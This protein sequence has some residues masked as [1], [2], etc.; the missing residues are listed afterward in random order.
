MRGDV[1]IMTGS[2]PLALVRL[3]IGVLASSARSV[4]LAVD[5]GVRGRE[6]VTSLAVRL[7]SVIGSRRPPA[8]RVLTHRDGF[9]V[10]G[11]YALSDTTQM[12]DGEPFGDRPIRLCVRPPM[13]HPRLTGC[14][15]ELPVLSVSQ[16]SRPN[17]TLPQLGSVLG[18][19]ASFIDLLPEPLGFCSAALQEGASGSLHSGIVHP[20]HPVR[21]HFP[22]APFDG[23]HVIRKH[24]HPPLHSVAG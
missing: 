15:V 6:F 14:R 7:R 16:A 17:P 11:A 4:P 24:E 18:N 10:A 9:Q 20:A 12:I 1:G 2:P 23:A 8:D 21:V 5:V 22:V 13:R 3:L 19:G